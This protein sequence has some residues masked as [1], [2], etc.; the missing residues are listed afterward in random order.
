VQRSL[1]FK[2]VLAFLL[3]SLIGVILVA[4]FSR[5]ITEREF[6][7]LTLAQAQSDFI[8]DVTTYY[9]ITGSI[10]GI[11]TAL[12]PPGQQSHLP[13]QPTNHR[14]QPQ[15]QLPPEARPQ[16]GLA[17]QS[18]RFIIPGPAFRVGDR[19][20]P[21]LLE[22][23]EPIEIDG[24][25]VGT[26]VT[27]NRPPVRNPLEE[28]YLARINQALL[29]AAVVAIL[30]AVAAGVFL[31]RTL[32]RPLQELTT[33][34]QAVA[35]GDLTQTVPVRSTDELGQLATA[36]NRMSSDL[37]RAIQQRRQMTADIAHDLRTPLTVITG[38]LEALR[39]GDL[40]PTQAR[41]EAMHEE[42]QHLGRL[43]S[44]LRTLSLADAGEL[45]LMLQPVLP[46]EL[47]KRILTGYQ[48]QATQQQ[49]ELTL[50]IEPDTPEFMAD[51]DR[52]VQV[53]GNLVSNAF[54]FT[55]E[56]GQ[57]SL[58][59]SPRSDGVLLQV[60]DT[61]SGI[62]TDQL[63]HIFNRF[64]RVDKSRSQHAGES[65]LGLAI[66]RVIVESHQGQITVDSQAGVGTTFSIYLPAACSP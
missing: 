27:L 35:A 25:I 4:L 59:A 29:L 62:P 22:A 13:S 53:L 28:Q 34:T 42:A 48:H 46:A 33:A 1:S 57:I 14:Q 56:G 49:V 37:A 64:Y 36:F 19:V 31:A 26:V 54:R 60:R 65:G 8:E 9:E 38:Y 39:D 40:S 17:D 30:V 66:A 5:F 51:W 18:G 15:Q 12:P 2:L 7:R 6:D 21:P 50:Q 47:F 3:V 32:T 23:G 63:P 10:Q 55:P 52:M 16:F 45:T 43:I 58:L 41:F 61:G 11:T 24:E 44:D 20:P